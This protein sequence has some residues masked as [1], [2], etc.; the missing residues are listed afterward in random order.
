VWSQNI[1]G[2]FISDPFDIAIDNDDDSILISGFFSGTVDFGGG[3]VSDAGSSLF[4][5]IFIASYNTY[6]AYRWSS[7][8]GDTLTDIGTAVAIAPGN[9]VVMGGS[10][11]LSVSFGGGALVAVG[12]VEEDAFLVKFEGPAVSGIGDRPP[13]PLATLRQNAPNPF[14]PSTVIPFSLDRPMD[15]SL[16]IYDIA[17]RHV[18]TLLSQALPAASHTYAWNGRDASGV[19]VPSGVYFYRLSTSTGM[20]TRKAILI[21]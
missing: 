9:D 5:D 13:S 6:G 19:P 10:F 16:A 1:G 12:V 15:V 17:G 11:H 21:R 3:T 7:T 14:G 20:Q 18:V 4:G 2:G 8:F